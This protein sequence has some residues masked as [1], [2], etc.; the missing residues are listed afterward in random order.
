MT[1]WALAAM[2]DLAYSIG[3][4]LTEKRLFAW[5][6][7]LRQPEELYIRTL[8]TLFIAAKD[9]IPHIFSGEW[10]NGLTRYYK[11]V[12]EI[13]FEGRGMLDVSQPGLNSGTFKAIDILHIGAHASF[14]AMMTCLGFALHPEYLPPSE[15]YLKHLD[16]YLKYLDYMHDMFKAGREKR[17]VLSGLIDLHGPASDR[18]NKQAPH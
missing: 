8:Y 2:V 5:F 16:T 4:D 9:E 3:R 12:N 13:V 15:K 10:P 6:S 17:D 14:P 7:R 11:K 18:A 1:S